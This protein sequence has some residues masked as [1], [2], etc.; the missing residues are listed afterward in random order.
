MEPTSY[1]YLTTY[2]EDI[3]QQLVTSKVIVLDTETS[4]LIPHVDK[5]TLLQLNTL[6]TG[7]LLIDLL[8]LSHS[9][10]EKLNT[11]FT[12]EKKLVGHNLKFDIKML[13]SL[14]IDIS[15]CKLFDTYVAYKLLNNHFDEPK[16]PTA[17]VEEKEET[18]ETLLAKKEK[19][20]VDQGSSLKIVIHRYLGI[21]ISKE[22]QRS[23]WTVR[24]LS[25]QQLSY[26]AT[27][28]D[29]FKV[30]ELI[31]QNLIDNSLVTVA[32][33]EFQCIPAVACMEYIGL[34][35]S[36][37][38]WNKL[39]PIYISHVGNNREQFLNTLGCNYQHTWSGEVHPSININ[40]PIQLRTKLHESNILDP[41]PDEDGEPRLLTSTNKD[42]IARLD[43]TEY[44]VLDYLTS[45][46]KSVKLVDSYLSSYVSHINP[47]TGNIHANFW[48]LGTKTGRFSCSKPNVQT[49]P[50]RPAHVAKDL[51]GGFM[52]PPGYSFVA[53]DFSQI[54]LRMM[55][56]LTKAKTWIAAFNAD[57]DLYCLYGA[58]FN[59]LPYENTPEWCRQFKKQYPELRQKAKPFV[60]G[61]IYGLGPLKA[62]NSAKSMYGVDVTLS[63]AKKIKEL[64][65]RDCPE[66]L[67]YIKSQYVLGKNKKELRTLSGRRVTGHLLYTQGSNIPDQGSCADVLKLAMGK[68]Y[69]Y[70]RD[71]EY[72]PGI[73]GTD[74]F[75]P[76]VSV[77]LCVHDE[78]IILCRDDL[79]EEYSAHL[80]KTMIET[81]SKFIKSIPVK[82]APIVGKTLA[83]VK[84]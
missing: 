57:L 78:I 26:A 40:S 22:E 82:S 2:P 8:C 50:S 17:V 48:Q 18:D 66:I 42:V 79:I 68:L 13:W 77:V 76:P 4:G 43:C 54:E 59:N 33:I 7:I 67:R 14:G 45:L 31:R 30:Y 53:S 62:K 9:D 24:P 81:A 51:K 41:D 6:A 10:I 69:A 23:D 11:V 12:P 83:E 84:D 44:P 60:L 15:R 52:A 37:E 5:P 49:V 19:D 74:N 20:E 16:N 28:V 39:L 58:K 36:K 70:Y 65:F 71:L 46:R 64:F 63:E 61:Y 55:A 75:Y 47:V 72:V 3:H 29:L 35:T 21:K 27:D 25:D 32:L 73:G 80:E 56:E 38:Y 1:R 34:H